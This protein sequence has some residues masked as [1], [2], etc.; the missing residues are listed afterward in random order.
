MLPIALPVFTAKA[1]TLVWDV[2]DKLCVVLPSLRRQWLNLQHS[3]WVLFGV[4]L[5]TIAS[6]VL[7][8]S[9]VESLHARTEFAR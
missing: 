4:Q 8:V 9:Q 1:H 2:I 5:P 6:V 7:A 3:E